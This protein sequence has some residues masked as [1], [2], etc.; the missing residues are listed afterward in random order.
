MLYFTSGVHQREGRWS[1][2]DRFP[3]RFGVEHDQGAV[4]W[5]ATRAGF[6]S[7]RNLN[8][9]PPGLARR[10]TRTGEV[11]KAGEPTAPATEGVARYMPAARQRAASAARPARAQT[12]GRPPRRR[13]GAR[14]RLRGP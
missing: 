13:G 4:R 2:F 3:A 5:L 1:G 11:A 7:A 14:P 10:G 12:G 6:G 9:W 8:E